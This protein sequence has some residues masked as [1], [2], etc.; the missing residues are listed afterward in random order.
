MLLAHPHFVSQIFQGH[1]F[2]GQG[3]TDEVTPLLVVE[4]ALGIASP[5][6][7]SRSIFPWAGRGLVSAPTRL[8]VSGRNLHPQRLVGPHL[9]VF[10][11]EIL[12]PTRAGG[13]VRGVPLPPEP[14]L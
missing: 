2:S 10:L 13:E 8:I 11:P 5:H 1:S 4:A 9:V 12:E 14:L 7:R 3:L 6:R